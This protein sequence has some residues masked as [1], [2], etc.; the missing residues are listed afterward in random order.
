MLS[1][2]STQIVKVLK[3]ENW[4]NQIKSFSIL[5]DLLWTCVSWN[6]FGSTLLFMIIMI[7]LTIAIT[8][9]NQIENISNKF[10]RLQ[11]SFK[12]ITENITFLILIQLVNEIKNF[13]Q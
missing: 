12:D 4:N 9:E 6:S 13:V 5:A 11:W 8:F 1:V 2:L 3:L 7:S 10:N